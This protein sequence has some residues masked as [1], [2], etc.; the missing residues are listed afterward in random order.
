MSPTYAN[1]FSSF[2]ATVRAENPI[3]VTDVFAVM[4]SYYQGTPYDLSKAGLDKPS[5]YPVAAG[6]TGT[7]FRAHAGAVEANSFPGGR[8][9]RPIAIWKTQASVVV[10]T[11]LKSSNKSGSASRRGV[12]WFAPHAAHTA[13]YMPFLTQDAG[14][15]PLP[16]AVSGPAVV[17]SVNR[18]YSF[19]ANRYVFTMAQM[20]FHLAIQDIASARAPLEREALTLLSSLPESDTQ[21]AALLGE[22]AASVVRAW[23]ALSE[24]LMVWYA[25][26]NC[27]GCPHP[28]G[29]GRHFGYPAW[30][31]RDAGYA[32][33]LP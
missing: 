4:R 3:A 23:W 8:W 26:G 17:S 13:V 30:W 5:D 2:P 28:T 20:R 16:A 22:N 19:W 10:C 9:E 25:E 1:F 29:S 33:P 32:D 31:L 6:P 18:T 27:N 7:S 14:N 24:Q 12:I 21:A 11:G 15:P